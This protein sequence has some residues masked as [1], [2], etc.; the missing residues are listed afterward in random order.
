MRERHDD[1]WIDNRPRNPQ[2][3][4]TL[5]TSFERKSCCSKRRRQAN[6]R[7][8]SQVPTIQPC[9]RLSSRAP[10]C[11]P[12]APASPARAVACACALGRRTPSA[13]SSPPRCPSSLS[14]TRSR[15]ASPSRRAA[16]TSRT[17][18]PRS[19][20]LSPLRS[21]GVAVVHLYRE[22]DR[23]GLHARYHQ[24]RDRGHRP[25]HPPPIWP[26]LL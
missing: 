4:K 25:L 8:R 10:S 11:S 9:H 24:P 20:T 17:T 13:T 7:P 5:L 15:A 23:P 22:P 1:P 16:V 6:V 3:S 21:A 12:P 18:Q 14:P 2:G 19:S 26:A